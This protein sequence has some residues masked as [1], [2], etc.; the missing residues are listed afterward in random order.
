VAMVLQSYAWN[1]YLRRELSS[2]ES[3]NQRALILIEKLYGKEHYLLG[4]VYNTLG[5]IYEKEKKYQQAIDSFSLALKIFDHVKRG[6]LLIHAASTWNNLGTCYYHLKQLSKAIECYEKAIHLRDT[7]WGKNHWLNIETTWALGACCVESHE[8]ES[9]VT[10]LEESISMSERVFGYGDLARILRLARTYGLAKQYKKAVDCYER[11]IK[12]FIQQKDQEEKQ[13]DNSSENQNNNVELELAV[14]WYEEAV[15][16]KERGEIKH[17][18]ELAEKVMA[19]RELRLGSDH[20]RVGRVVA[21]LA[22]CYTA[23]GNVL[24]GAFF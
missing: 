1:E 14:I 8:Y 9:A 4:R 16:E 18:L 5:S 17:A 23:E 22:E 21:L 19:I 3:L 11:W 7:L 12:F 13:L 20:P 2:S 10:H 15:I 24:S 6:K